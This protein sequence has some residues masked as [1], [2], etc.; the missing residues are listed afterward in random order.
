[1]GGRA[2]GAL[3]A[4]KDE[5]DEGSEEIGIWIDLQTCTVSLVLGVKTITAD[6]KDIYE[7]GIPR[8]IP[9][10]RAPGIAHISLPKREN[11]AR[12][13]GFDVWKE[14]KRW[15]ADGLTIGP[16]KQTYYVQRSV[17]LIAV[18]WWFLFTISAILP[19]KWTWKRLR[20][21]RNR[22]RGFEVLVTKGEKQT[23]ENSAVDQTRCDFP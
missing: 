17:R 19:G 13:M 22:G 14:E 8:D 21:L 12:F 11:K 2:S 3:R 7:Q 20:H 5:A 1:M 6:T 23:E 16:G 4:I 15:S 18:P 9:P 10:W